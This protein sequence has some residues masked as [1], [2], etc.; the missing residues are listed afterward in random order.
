MSLVHPDLD[1]KAFQRTALN[2]LNPLSILQ[3]G[4]HLAR[5]LRAHL[6]QRYDDAIHILRRSM[7]PPLPSTENLGLGVFFHLPPVSFVA[8]YG[9]DPAHSAGHDPFE[10]SM[11]AQYELTRR[12]IAEFSIRPFLIRWPERTL[13]QLMWWTKDKVPMCGGSV[14][15]EPVRACPGRC[16][17]RPS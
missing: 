16:E 9:L 13:A 10:I 6:P 5:T 12:F 14:Q 17:F 8:T 4:H 2:D 15:R 3:R 7:T 11:M 1:G